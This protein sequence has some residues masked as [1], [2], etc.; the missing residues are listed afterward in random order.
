MTRGVRLR[1]G[2]ERSW[3]SAHISAG[4]IPRVVGRRRRLL[5]VEGVVMNRRVSWR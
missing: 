3:L 4:L 1:L 2:V 5:M